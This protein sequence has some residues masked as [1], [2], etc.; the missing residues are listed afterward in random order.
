MRAESWRPAVAER[1]VVAIVIEGTPADL[2][3]FVKDVRRSEMLNSC[4]NEEGAMVGVT[5]IRVMQRPEDLEG[6]T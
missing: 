6:R 4:D 3:A 1:W 5:G 2:A